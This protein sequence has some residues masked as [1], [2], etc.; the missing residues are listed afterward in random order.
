MTLLIQY[1]DTDVRVYVC[2]VLWML[3]DKLS[4]Q[5]LGEGT[6]GVFLLEIVLEHADVSVLRE[7]DAAVEREIGVALV[8]DVFR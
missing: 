8:A 6:V 1:G 2:Y 5:E 7:I 4:Q 3:S